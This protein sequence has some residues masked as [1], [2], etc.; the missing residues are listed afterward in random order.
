MTRRACS[1]S[2]WPVSSPSRTMI[3]SIVAE[4]YDALA[5]VYARL[6]PEA[7]RTPEG[8]AAAFAGWVEGPRV[9]DCACGTG[10]L[11]AGL[12]RRGFRVAGSDA[13]PGMI[14]RAR[15]LDPS[16]PFEVR[17]WE[18]LEEDEFDTVLCVGNSLAHAADR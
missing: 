1:S 8:A 3:F 7:L 17:R 12:A 11:A 15:R 2:S 13:S 16:V 10:E 5:P 9:L 4:Q 18:D 14:E 6:V